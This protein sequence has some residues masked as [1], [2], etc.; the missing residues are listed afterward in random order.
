M[1]SLRVV[2]TSMTLLSPAEVPHQ[3]VHATKRVCVSQGAED[4]E[5]AV[6]LQGV[7]ACVRCHEVPA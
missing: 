7:V 6:V 5:R 1:T 2:G 4:T 3:S